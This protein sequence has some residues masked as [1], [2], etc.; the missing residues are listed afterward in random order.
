VA[1][2]VGSEQ[3]F[4]PYGASHGLAVAG[5]ALLV[6]IVV[7]LG[8]RLRDSAAERVLRG[9]LASF[10]LAFWAAYNAW[11]SL[12]S[13]DLATNLPLHICDFAGVIA[14]LALV[15]T[16]RWLRA[17]LY[18]WASTLTLQAFIQPAL[19]AGP[20]LAYFWTFWISHMLILACATY[21][22]VVRG[23]RPDA[24]DFGRAAA[25]T[26]AYL[27]FITPVNLWL[28]SNYGFVGNPPPGRSLP[29]MVEALGAWPGRVVIMAG[30]VLLG[31][32]LALSPWLIVAR[33]SGARDDLA[34][35]EISPSGSR[36]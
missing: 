5:C 4:I 24:G 36:A 14:P 27:A 34:R 25:V 23:F 29:P 32:L 9:G 17:T 20:A 10:A 31:F 22:L 15:T 18:F 26:L 28:D 6:A 30:L 2:D 12:S 16:N 19:H 21:D 7:A 11:W 8:Y 33:R 3:V 13:D 35:D 1:G